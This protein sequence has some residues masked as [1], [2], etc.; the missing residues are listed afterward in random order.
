MLSLS[1]CM[2]VLLLQETFLLLETFKIRLDKNFK[3]YPEK[4]YASV[5]RCTR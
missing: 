2:H 5:G 1:L 3:I 4:N